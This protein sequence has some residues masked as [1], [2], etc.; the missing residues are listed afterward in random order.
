MLGL[1]NSSSTS[2]S[3]SS[4]TV[5]LS[6]K[7]DDILD[8]KRGY[9]MTKDE[10]HGYLSSVYA[11]ENLEFLQA[12]KGL[13]ARRDTGSITTQEV[14]KVL[15]TYVKSDSNKQINISQQMRSSVIE[16]FKQNPEKIDDVFDEPEKEVKQL[17]ITQRHVQKFEDFELPNLN[18]IIARKR[19]YQGLA[20][21]LAGLIFCAILIAFVD[22]LWV[23]IVTLPFYVV[24][25]TLI[26]CKS[27][28]MPS[29]SF[30]AGEV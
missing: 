18:S 6:S 23:R 28:N 5:N 17:L 22:I 12:V 19:M 10:F 11:E 8:D 13:K 29:C 15:D 9:P 7:L 4:T 1:A 30:L 27:G 14:E 2:S 24:G 3:V 26:Q 16:K 20:S 21:G 25:A